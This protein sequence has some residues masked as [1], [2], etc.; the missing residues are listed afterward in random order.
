MSMESLSFFAAVLGI[1]NTILQN[2]LPSM[3]DLV[4]HFMILLYS[5]APSSYSYRA[6][7]S[8][9]K[10]HLL[11]RRRL[12]CQSLHYLSY[13]S[14]PETLA[15]SSFNKSGAWTSVR[16]SIYPGHARPNTR[17]TV[18]DAN[19]LSAMLSF[20]ATVGPLKIDWAVFTNV[21]PTPAE[22]LW[23][24]SGAKREDAKRGLASREGSQYSS[25][26]LDRSIMRQSRTPYG[27]LP[28]KES[29]VDP[30]ILTLAMAKSS[31]TSRTMTEPFPAYIEPSP[32]LQIDYEQARRAYD[33]PTTRVK[34]NQ[35]PTYTELGDT[36]LEFRGEK[37]Q[38]PHEC[39]VL[40]LKRAASNLVQKLKNVYELRRRDN[41][42]LEGYSPYE[43]T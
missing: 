27:P 4:T 32:L 9:C 22:H 42:M 11:H 23:P 15:P 18:K 40:I 2:I 16:F 39:K 29:L 21:N 6:I 20:P 25:V 43:G 19:I 24:P 34:P 35:E 5:I 37:V 7:R 8:R 36:G 38:R 33:P 1:H 31:A 14:C 13:V 28:P 17:H 10:T 3:N 12:L 30:A 41:A 26:T